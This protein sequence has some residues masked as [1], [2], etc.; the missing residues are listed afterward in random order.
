MATRRLEGFKMTD[1]E[2]QEKGMCHCLDWDLMIIKIGSNEMNLC[3][4][5]CIIRDKHLE[6]IRDEKAGGF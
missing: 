1:K 2:A 3:T 4:I 5:N 6:I